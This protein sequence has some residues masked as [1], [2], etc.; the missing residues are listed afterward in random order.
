[1]ESTTTIE[2]FQED[3][4]G[5]KQELSSIKQE[6]HHFES[7]LERMA[8]EKLPKHQLASIEHFQNTFICQ[9][10]VIDKLRHDLPDSKQ[11]VESTYNFL[12]SK[13]DQT[14]H[15]LAERME[16]FRR[17]YQEIKSDF[18]KFMS[19]RPLQASSI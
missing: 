14:K 9:K 2:Q 1:M 3:L 4:H 7:H 8:K 5:W 16:T 15:F 13:A 12:N 6:I 11:K 10:E 18:N 19:S 17:I